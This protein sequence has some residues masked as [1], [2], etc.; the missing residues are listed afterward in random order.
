M[1]H[2]SFYAQPSRLW[3]C[4][5]T[6]LQGSMVAA[7]LLV[8]AQVTSAATPFC[9]MT[10]DMQKKLTLAEVHQP[11]LVQTQPPVLASTNTTTAHDHGSHRVASQNMAPNPQHVNHSESSTA[12]AH[13]DDTHNT[14]A[15]ACACSVSCASVTTLQPESLKI[16]AKAPV[17]T[18]AS[19]HRPHQLSGFSPR[20]FRPPACS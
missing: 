20:H 14:C 19:L 5:S 17:A 3:T 8:F 9:K 7:A 12:R 6:K 11:A 15:T 13:H 4:L 2:Y 10:M 18:V 1:R 16:L